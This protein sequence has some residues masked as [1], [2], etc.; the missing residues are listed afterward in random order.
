[1]SQPYY[2]VYDAESADIDRRQKYAEALR[3]Q[4]MEQLPTGQMAGR[5]FVPTSPLAGIAKALQAY[6][7]A[8]G[9]SDLGNERRALAERM[10]TERGT[11]MS[12]M[13]NALRGTPARPQQLDP[14]ESAQM[15]DQG[16]PMPPQMPA[17]PGDPNQA[18]MLAMQSRVPSVQGMA[19]ALMQMGEARQTREDNQQ[20]KT[21]QAALARDQRAAE[22]KMRSE[23]MRLAAADRAA[24]S[25]ELAAMNNAARADMAAQS[26][27]TRRDIAEMTRA[28]GAK[29]PANYR[30]TPNGDL[31]AIPG[32]PADQKMQG[33]FNQDTAAL[34]G[35]TGAM[36]RL[37]VAANEAMTHPGLAGITGL[38]GA[39]PNIPGSAAAD[40][41][42]KLNTLKSQVAF[43]VLQD[44]RN[45][46]KT[47]GALGSVSDAEG[48]RLEAN[49][50]ALEN[51]QS[52]EQMKDSLKKIIDYTSGA[53]ER[54]Q[55]AYNLKHQGRR[56]TDAKP[57]AS[58]ATGD[59][60]IVR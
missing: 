16:S 59:W 31:E 55:G 52:V 53:K 58:G 5:V 26:N 35:S 6:Q 56:A 21:E 34:T 50:A 2:G 9:V 10:E 38:R 25:K 43:G 37:A 27:A 51:A 7:G 47:G 22:L 8:K 20:F 42:A 44:M 15:A 24:A 19:P 13:V 3:Q 17:V 18:A 40:A 28:Q 39:L 4:G 14:Q 32:G 41:Q 33:A 1:M 12:A 29:P 60:S 45:N 36:D 11:D 57:A 49:L 54:L 46:S 23:D 30:Y 48:K